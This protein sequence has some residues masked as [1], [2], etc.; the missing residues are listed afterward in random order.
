MKV[1]AVDHFAVTVSDT[2]RALEFYVGKLGL[3]QVEQHQL[4]GDGCDEVCGHKG[5]RAQSTR[6]IAEGT[7][8]ILID[9]LELF[10]PQLEPLLPPFDAVG[11]CHF[12]LTVDDLPG[13]VKELESKG[14]EF[15][16]APVAFE[17]TSGT[18]TVCFCKDPDGNYVELMEEYVH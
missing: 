11:S 7:P 9:L 16:S 17:I 1:K 3:K 13:A 15:T 14:V 10:E 5:T 2:E 18:V 6:L 8:D 12:A 4:E